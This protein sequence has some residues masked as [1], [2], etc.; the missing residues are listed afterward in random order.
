[1]LSISHIELDYL[2]WLPNWKSRSIE[3]LRE[4]LTN[5]CKQLEKNEWV[6]DGNYLLNE[7]SRD[8]PCWDEMRYVIFLDFDFWLVFYRSWK[9]TLRRIWHREKICNG[10]VE[11]WTT[12]LQWKDCIPY[13]VIKV[14][15]QQPKKVSVALSQHPHVRWIHLRSPKECD[16]WLSMIS[17]TISKS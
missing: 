6:M 2:H 12:L 5:T 1:M 9:R 8:H 3:S 15:H 4:E 11:T 7:K 10:N 17:Q 14:H 13:W 16:E